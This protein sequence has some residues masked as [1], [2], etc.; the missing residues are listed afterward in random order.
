MTMKIYKL[1]SPNQ[2]NPNINL[3][4]VVEFYTRVIRD[5]EGIMANGITD[6]SV[7]LYAEYVA[8]NT[9]TE[10]NLRGSSEYRTH[11]TKVLTE[12]NLLRIGGS[13]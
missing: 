10:S 13:K 8:N 12:R 1:E 5:E 2:V 11:L 9:P 7:K 6:D 3:I 4:R